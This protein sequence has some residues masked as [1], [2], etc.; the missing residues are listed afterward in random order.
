MKKFP[1]E[2]AQEANK[3][4]KLSEWVVEYLIGIGANRSLASEI[5]K[6]PQKQWL[7]IEFPL[8]KLKRIMGPEEGLKYPESRE[9]WERRVAKY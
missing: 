5:Q 8:R 4:G 3:E 6:H 2:G 7:L 9:D 1:V